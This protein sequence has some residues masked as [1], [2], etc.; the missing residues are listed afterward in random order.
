VD[1]LAHR[2]QLQLLVQTG[3]SSFSVGSAAFN[4]ALNT[5]HHLAVTRSGS[6]FSFYVDGALVSTG[7]SST[8][9]PAITAPLTIGES[10][11]TF[12]MGGLEDEVTIY[13]RALSAGEIDTI[14]VEGSGGKCGPSLAPFILTQPQ[15]QTVF[16]GSNVTLGVS[17]GGSP[18]LAYQ[19][20]Y[21]GT[22]ISTNANPTAIDATLV[23]NNA[24]PAQS[25][26]YSVTVSNPAGATNSA[27]A[28]LAVLNPE[29]CLPAPAG[30]VSWWKAEGDATDAFGDNNGSLQNGAGFA[31]G[32]VGMAFAFANGPGYIQVPDSPSLNFGANDFTIELWAN[33]PSLTVSRALIAKDNGP[34]AQNK[35][36]FWLNGGQLQFLIGTGA[37]SVSLGTGALNVA[38]NTWHH[39]AVTRSGSL[40]SFYVDGALISTGS[41]SAPV[42]AI[43][44]PLTI[45][46]AEGGNFMGGLEDEVTIYGRALGATEI[47]TI[48]REGSVGKCG[49]PLAPFIVAQPVGETVFAGTAATLGVSA[50]GSPPLN[51]QW[52]LDGANIPPGT[53]PTSGSAELML[54]DLQPGQS[55][56]YSV[57]VSNAG[58][59]TNSA[60]AAVTVLSPGS[61]LPPPSGII[62]TWK[63]EGTAADSA[64]ANNGALSG[65][66]GYAAGEVGAAFSF[67]NGNGYVQVPD[68]PGL[69][70]GGNDFSIELWANF[71]SLSGNRALIAKDNGG[72]S[73]NKWV[74]WLSNGQLQFLIGTGAS[75]VTF[76][77]GG[78]NP[79]LNTWHH[80]AVTRSGSLFSLYADGTL[81]STGSSITPV[82]AITAPLTI[83]EAE[84][85]AFMGGLEDE[86]TIYGRALDAGEIQ[87]IYE[88][89]SY[90]KCGPQTPPIVITQPQNQSVFTGTT[91]D[92]GVLASG[93]EPLAYQWQVNGTNISA[94]DNPS[95]ATATLVLTNA[96]PDESGGYSVLVSNGVGSTNSATA[97]LVVRDQDSC[98]VPPGVVSWWTAEGNAND[99]AGSNPGTL[100][101]GTG[102]AP[103][104]VGQAFDFRNGTGYVQVPDS[105]SLNFG[106]NDFSIELWA[107]F[108]SLGG[109]R[110]LI[111]KDNGP[112]ANNKWIFW[113]NGGQ[114]QFLI[115]TGQSGVSV[116]SAAFNPALNT[117][118][119]LAVNRSGSLFSFYLD[120]ALVSTGTSSTPIP[121]IT[122]PLT[123]GQAEGLYFMGGLEDEVT[124]YARAL[125]P[126]EV[127][128]IYLAGTAGKCAPLMAPILV[129]QPQAGSVFAGATADFSVVAGGSPP[130]G[131]QWQFNGTSITNATN[132]TLIL[133][134]AQPGESGNYSVTVFNA[135][136]STNSVSV[137]LT[138]NI[139]N[140]VTPPAGIVGWWQGEGNA[141]DSASTNHGT[142]I[143]GV[144][145]TNGL[146]GQAF[147]FNGINQYVDVPNSA[148]LNPTNSV[149]LEAWINPAQFPP[150]SPII[151]KAGQGPGGPDGYTLELGN[152]SGVLFGVYVNG[153]WVDTVAALVPLNQW[154]HVA[155]VYDGTNLYAYVNGKLAAGPVHAPGTIAPSGNDLNIG[156]D[157]SNPSRY[158]NGLIDEATVYSSA[159]SAAQILA[160][161]NANYAGKCPIPLPPSI[162]LQP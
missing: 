93:T 39:L 105:P 139:A 66:A 25:G 60:V 96:Q 100:E 131:Y 34:G 10:E 153:A 102:F 90:G 42:P 99:S 55:G 127:Q 85:S 74:F 53:N 123:I 15:G 40:F 144:G 121:A 30:I 58:G 22:N 117:W 63:G 5:W 130:L 113:L 67:T 114:L 28:A 87:S 136:G 32:E 24:Q 128:S 12:F 156:H 129:T 133:T 119:H 3:A 62:S 20:E 108:T 75:S 159:L 6:L 141:L 1:L 104:E 95:A 16:A 120:G 132:A 78:F 57:V 9:I 111:A 124:I 23:L 37:T 33:F 73:Q 125:S 65:T 56:N 86:V 151:K 147:S 13:S 79:A 31:A 103:G 54:T 137:P 101:G 135:A 14:Y 109:S 97:Q 84:N 77:T 154:T 98:S 81:V 91:V 70:F 88:A 158:F 19:W 27:A 92:L 61:C 69:N 68:S 112:G 145:F 21:N 43:T 80:L 157:A 35:W 160:I 41:S 11:N 49:T 8:P 140:C 29:T 18:S 71:T 149:T 83:G 116:G 64:G 146:V 72:G 122:A 161:Y 82:P 162:A 17:A 138:V 38:P 2:G 50:G 134:D 48:Y 94:A 148:S 76:G 26:N 142:L 155:G 59:S 36:I 44:A 89:G 107:N 110:A 152:S 47:Q 143:N 52:Q 150:S 115:Q 106:G 45:G 51:Y 7:S 46:A 118:H 126:T 4:P